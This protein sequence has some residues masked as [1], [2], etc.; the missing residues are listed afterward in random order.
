MP[1]D[2][3]HRRC[4]YKKVSQRKK[5]ARQQ[6]S[7]SSGMNIC[8]ESQKDLGNARGPSHWVGAWLTPGNA[9]PRHRQDAQVRRDTTLLITR[10]GRSAM[11]ACC[12]ELVQQSNEIKMNI[13]GRKA[14][15]TLMGPIA[16]DPLLVRHPS[17]CAEQRS[18]EFQYS[19]F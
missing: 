8:K 16:K 4:Y 18:V 5:N 6:L 2:C 1:N 15:E 9:L 3:V 19:S 13:I 11:N 14:K 12:D 17:R 7:V 10:S